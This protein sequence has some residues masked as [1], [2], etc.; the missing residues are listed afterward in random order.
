MGWGANN[1]LG[2]ALALDVTLGAGVGK[3]RTSVVGL[4]VLARRA[5]GEVGGR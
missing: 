2:E 1:D 5:S 4:G 3:L